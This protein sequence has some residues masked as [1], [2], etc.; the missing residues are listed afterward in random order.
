M[1]ASDFSIDLPR[2]RPY[3]YSVSGCVCTERE[4][5]VEIAS[6]VRAEWEK[7]F[8]GPVMEQAL[9][10]VQPYTYASCMK[11]EYLCVPS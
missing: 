2:L 1:I 6:S 3:K 11:C 7:E 4:E 10:V 9:Q 5:D 8:R